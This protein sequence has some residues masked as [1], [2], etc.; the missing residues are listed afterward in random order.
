M[1]SIPRIMQ[2]VSLGAEGATQMAD[3]VGPFLGFGH[4]P[5]DE[6]PNSGQQCISQATNSLQLP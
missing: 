3:P 5:R 6:S 4:L 1:G 2:K